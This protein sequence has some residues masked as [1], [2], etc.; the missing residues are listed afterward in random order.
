MKGKVTGDCVTGTVVAVEIS[1]FPGREIHASLAFLTA[2]WRTG[3][4]LAQ[5]G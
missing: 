2:S 4:V 5:A 3:H 1:Y